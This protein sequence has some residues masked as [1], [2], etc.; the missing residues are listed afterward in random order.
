MCIFFCSRI[1][2]INYSSKHKKLAGLVD[3]PPN[4]YRRAESKFVVQI[5]LLW[6]TLIWWINLYSEFQYTQQIMKVSKFN[7]T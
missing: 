2:K 5:T 4:A 6:K 7:F 1:T 3:E